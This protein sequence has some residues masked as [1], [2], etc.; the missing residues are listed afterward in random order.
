MAHGAPGRQSR[1]SGRDE[2]A[3]LIAE[4]CLD[5]KRP[6]GTDPKQAL[7]QMAEHEPGSVAG[8]YRAADKVAAYVALKLNGILHA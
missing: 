8:F 2:M 5:L 7:A 1:P 4:G 6:A 3:L